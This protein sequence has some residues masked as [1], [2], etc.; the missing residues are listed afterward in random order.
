MAAKAKYIARWGGDGDP[1]E[2]EFDK[3]ASAL[4]RARL[5][6]K[7]GKSAKVVKAVGSIESP[8]CDYND[9]KAEKANGPK[10]MDQIIADF[11]QREGSMRMKLLTPLVKTIGRPVRSDQ[12]EEQMYGE[13]CKTS[14]GAVNMVLLGLQHA[15]RDHKLNYTIIVEKIDGHRTIALYQGKVGKGK[16]KAK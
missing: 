2:K 6:S 13:A 1:K 3:L 16:G 10:N 7:G 5:E 11:Q 15:I 4:N 9:G 12:L 14:R 8:V